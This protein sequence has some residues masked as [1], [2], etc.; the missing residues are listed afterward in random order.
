MKRLFFLLSVSLLIVAC[1]NSGSADTVH[2]IKFQ[3]QAQGTYYAVTYFAADTL[4]SQQQ[5]DSL[6]NAF[7][8]CASIYKPQSVISRM[9]RNDSTVGADSLFTV[10]FNAAMKVSERTAGAFD[11]TVGQLVNAWGFGFKNREKITPALVDS[12]RAFVGY[13]KV[14]LQGKVLIKEDPR[15]ML[16]FNAI[17]QGFSDD[18]LAN[19]MESK[20]ITNYL[21][22]IGGEVKARGKKSNGDSWMVAIEKPAPDK[23]SPQELKA[24]LRLNDRSLATSGSY[25]KY[26]EENGVRYSH[27]IDPST[28]YPVKHNLLSVSVIAGDCITADAYATAFM[29]MGLDKIKEFQA[30]NPDLGLLVYCIY[31]APD[32]SMQ[33]WADEGFRALITKEE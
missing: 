6:L 21:I 14:K 19:F 22:D 28:G 7:D 9:N 24:T 12:L 18:L 16:D 27:T 8:L 23:E 1:N 26:Y 5:I 25:R 4:V 11:V 33:V 17:A 13:H 32:G 31:S 29:V 10:I 20:G 3:G 30:N 15:I 2:K